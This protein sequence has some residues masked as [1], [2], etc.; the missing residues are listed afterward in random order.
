MTTLKCP[1]CSNFLL[2]RRY[3]IN[4]TISKFCYACI[5][6]NEEIEYRNRPAFSVERVVFLLKEQL[7]KLSSRYSDDEL[8]KVATKIVEEA[9]VN[10][11]TLE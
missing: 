1:K 3:W 2:E 5:I 10:S 11:R 6:C 9:A 8:L 7:Y 4:G